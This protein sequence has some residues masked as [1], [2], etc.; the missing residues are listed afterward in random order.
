MAGDPASPYKRA[1][2]THLLR[3]FVVELLCLVRYL[4]S[5]IPSPSLSI[6]DIRTL[7]FPNHLFLLSTQV[8]PYFLYTGNVSGNEEGESQGRQNKISQ[9]AIGRVTTGDT[10]RPT[11]VRDR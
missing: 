11:P 5:I 4:Y 7:S 10:A 9:S 2:V 1:V 8:I 6:S 3:L